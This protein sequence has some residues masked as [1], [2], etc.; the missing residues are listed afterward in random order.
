MLRTIIEQEDNKAL[1]KIVM[2]GAISGAAN[3]GVLA[4]V[5][6]AAE[7]PQRPSLVLLAMLIVAAGLF[8]VSLRLCVGMLS[9]LLEGMLRKMRIRIADKI[10]RAELVHL[11]SIGTSELYERL[12]QQTNEISAATWPISTSVQSA[13]LV[14]CSIVY[15]AYTS[16]AALLLTLGIYG[17]TAA[18][19][20]FRDL[21][22]RELMQKA[23]GTRIR[24]LDVLSDLLRGFKEVR[25]RNQ[26]SD[27]LH[28]DFSAHAEQLEQGTI[29]SNLLQQSN[30]VFANL[31][32]FALLASAVFILPQFTG[33]NA[34]EV[35]KIT[36]VLLFLFGPV[37]GV[38]FGLPAYT[39]ASLAC[40]RISE[41]EQRLDAMVS[42]P[43]NKNPQGHAEP[44]Q[45]L[46]LV[47]LEFQRKDTEGR[48]L[49]T[50]GPINLT[51]RA[52]EI[53]F[54]VGG[55]GSG[56]TTLLRTMSGLYPPTAGALLVNG[57]TVTPWN[58]QAYREK[59]AA[60]FTD[61]HLF[62]RLYGL[63]E[64][65]A[66]Q[67]QKLLEQMEIAD[68]T[69]L[70]EGVWTTVELSTGQ[71]K[72]VAMVVALLE[73][74]PIY[75]FDEW[76]ADQDPEFRRYFYEGLL[77]ELKRQ[78]KAVIAISHDDR[79]F[80]CADRVVTLEYGK[81][82]SIDSHVI[83]PSAAAPTTELQSDRSHCLTKS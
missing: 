4:I 82:R 81:V 63:Q 29:Q 37:G 31:S 54:L 70:S 35:Q 11:E 72:R 2:A 28:A 14:L 61:F 45:E 75:I 58:V 19:Y 64:A 16:L 47:D 43:Q 65:Q 76:A 66:E 30:F 60:I 77:Q 40:Q 51:V 79:Y 73:D 67:V 22:S 49:F 13:V 44:F 74:R 42:P 32:Q 9:N 20:Y 55:N 5:N 18:L 48:P 53:V 10:R 26:R 1:T 25:L 50:V 69:S 46:T 27:E 52:G 17:S 38:L 71:R 15:L 6:T 7:R 83:P 80:N 21:S 59:I 3:A 36:A 24:L 12:T 62:K 78:G 23:A 57:V 68:K 34:Q 56:K 33:S 39:K 41:L 8:A